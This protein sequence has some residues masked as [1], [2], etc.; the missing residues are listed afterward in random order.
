MEEL[1]SLIL[2]TK[3]GDLNAYGTIVRRFQDMAVGYSYSLLN[4][5]QLAEDA[6]QEAFIEAFLKLS[7]LQNPAAFPGWFRKIIFKH[8][9]RFTRDAPASTISLEDSTEI[10]SSEP[11]PDE[12]MEAKE[13]KEKVLQALRNLAEHERTVTALYYIDG[14]SQK[15]ISDFLELPVTTVKKRLHDSRKRLKERMIEMVSESLKDHSPD[16]H[17]SEK[18]VGELLNRPKPM[19]IEGHPV[20]TIWE[21]IRT[22]LSSYEI[23]GGEEIVNRSVEE[24][25][26]VTEMAYHVSDNE[27]LRTHTT[28][29]TFQAI[30]GRKPPVRLL[31]AGRVFRP[32]R[33]DRNHS[34]VFHQVD[35]ICIDQTADIQALKSTVRQTLIAVFGE[36]EIRWRN[37]DFKFVDAGME[38]DIRRN[39]KWFGIGGCGLLK[40]DML[41]QAG[42]NVNRVSGF[43]FG[44]GIERITM[45]K[46]G[47]DDI[48]QL[49]KSPYVPEG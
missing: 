31:A 29:T 13:L 26:G 1:Q 23:I 27:I 24:D 12:I 36:V 35:G 6:A 17:F 9:D 4:D 33:E 47:I 22:A 41:R 3:S 40:E 7:Q 16:E 32:D 8:C 45:I 19:E 5:F 44:L 28:H 14:Y 11:S 48:H 42:F 30:K 15:E 49:W 39:E 2:R 25:M 43:A 18:V 21:Q 37:H 34:K 46:L 38:F 20:R 10:T